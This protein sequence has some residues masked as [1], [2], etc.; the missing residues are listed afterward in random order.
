MY[1]QRQVN[2]TV[3]ESESTASGRAQEMNDDSRDSFL[4]DHDDDN[5]NDYSYDHDE[6]I[7]R[8]A[9]RWHKTV[10]PFVLVRFS[11]WFFFGAHIALRVLI[12]T[13]HVQVDGT[14]L[15]IYGIVVTLRNSEIH[16]I[17][18]LTTFFEVFY[19]NHCYARYLQLYVLTRKM[20]KS[21]FNFCYWLRVNI[22]DEELRPY[23]RMAS[24]FA[25]LAVHLFFYE[26][27]DEMS[28]AQW[29]AL[30]TNGLVK[31]DERA[32]L[33]R[34]VRRDRHVAVLCWSGDVARH[35]FKASKIAAAN[36]FK[37]MIKELLFIQ[38]LQQEL[39]DMLHLPV[40]FPY[41]HLLSLMVSVNL[42]MW[43]LSMA[44]SES[45]VSTVVFFF[46][47]L[48]FMG[49]LQLANQ[50][51]DPFGDDD[52]DFQADV[53]VADTLKICCGMI[54]WDYEPSKNA[55]KEKLKSEVR[56]H[57][58]MLHLGVDRHDEESHRETPNDKTRA[59]YS[60]ANEDDT[61]RMKPWRDSPRG[62]NHKVESWHSEHPAHAAQS[63]N[64]VMVE[65]PR[66]NMLMTS[67]PSIS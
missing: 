39:L 58:K 35:G 36:S 4:Q 14:E 8:T 24:R 20:L 19:S 37:E 67:R 42:M 34:L 38:E 18:A 52:V 12:H 62:L 57:P 6:D 46:C 9:I 48:I 26:V 47:E 32:Y 16:I 3:F 1:Y 54:D 43:A 56:L 13:G 41:Y 51:S 40:P 23:I 17:T 60:R 31:A 63:R 25:M 29:S 64:M 21:L 33:Q 22:A 30:E 10:L 5:P 44:V 53:W 27:N 45:H 59:R 28:D 66:R 65:Q 2:A 11:F 7:I 49:L 61:E 15:T 50:L 55:W